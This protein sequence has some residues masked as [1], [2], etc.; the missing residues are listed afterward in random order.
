MHVKTL[1]LR[2]TLQVVRFHSS[3]ASF[4]TLIVYSIF[5]ALLLGVFI[6]VGCLVVNVLHYF[7]CC[8][9][10]PYNDENMEVS[11]Q[12]FHLQV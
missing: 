8:I 4:Y 7:L 9:L 10:P 3:E 2:Y 1:W 11:S 5:I 12:E 6:M